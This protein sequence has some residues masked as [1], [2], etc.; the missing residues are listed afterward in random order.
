MRRGEIFWKGREKD[1]GVD[2]EILEEKYVDDE[3]SRPR[4]GQEGRLLT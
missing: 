2:H 1:D 4:G 3:A